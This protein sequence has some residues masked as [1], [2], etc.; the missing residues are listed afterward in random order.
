MKKLANFLS[1]IFG[2]LLLL[3]SMLVVIETIGRKWLGFSLQGVD[4]LGGYI[5]AVTTGLAFTVAL[6]DRAH[7]RIDLFYDRCS[8]TLRPWLDWLSLLLVA[9]MS[10]LLSYVA[11]L[12]LRETIE[13]GSTAP[14]PWATPMV[15]PQGFWMAT[16]IL[17]SLVAIVTFAKASRLLL[18][19]SF[20]KLR[21]DYGL[22]V[23]ADELKEELVAFEQ[24]SN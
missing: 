17:F 24:R 3:L 14:T 5:L 15:W 11:L 2:Y 22:K 7:I 13:F 16:L 6:I 23:V 8:T 9:C 20:D 21:H 10:I 4:E 19:G 12:S 18:V 1:A